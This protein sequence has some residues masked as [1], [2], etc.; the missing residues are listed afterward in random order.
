MVPQ[1]R[2]LTPALSPGT[3]GRGS[4]GESVEQ[5]ASRHSE[6]S[7]ESC[8]CHSRPLT[9]VRGDGRQAIEELFNTLPRT[10]IGV[11]SPS[12]AILV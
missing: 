3:R 8:L 11:S 1:P 6:R 10:P 9:Y 2:L 5:G 12:Y 4:T 7:E